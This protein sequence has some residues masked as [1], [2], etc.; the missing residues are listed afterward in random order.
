M[1]RGQRDH[2]PARPFGDADVERVLHRRRVLQHQRALPEVVQHQ[3]RQ[4]EEVPGIADGLGA[5]MAHVGVDRLA[6]GH[7]QHHRAEDEEAVAAVRHE[8]T[9]RPDRIERGQHL[10][11]ACDVVHAYRV[12][13]FV[14]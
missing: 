6:A 14:V 12:L 10:R 2:R 11:I 5:E 7:R 13:M 9:Q 4:H 8:E 3:R 1:R